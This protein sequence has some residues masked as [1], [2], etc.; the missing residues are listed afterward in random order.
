MPT[1]MPPIGDQVVLITGASSGIGLV[2]ARLAASRGARV[3]LVSRNEA[4]LAEIVRGIE[5][6]GG[7]ACFAVADVGDRAALTRAAE[8]GIARFGRIDTWVNNAGVAIYAT[9]AETPDDE[10]ERL[11]RT[12][13]FGVVNGAHIAL[14]LFG[15]RGGAL[16]T[17]A[18]IAADMS[19]PIM[20]A[21]AASKHAV[22]AFVESLRIELKA[23]GSPISVSL[24]KPSGIATPIGVHAANHLRGEAMIPP[25]PYDPHLVAQAILRCAERPRRE[26]TVGGAGRAQVL[27]AEH[28]PAL[29]E[30]LAPLVVPFLHDRA[31]PKSAGSNLFGPGKDGD[32]RSSREAGFKLS[33]YTQAALRPRLA[34][35]LILSSAA[36]VGALAIWR[37]RRVRSRILS[38]P[39]HRSGSPVGKRPSSRP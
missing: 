10:H 6:E 29:F 34:A 38:G 4:A 27:F 7:Q 13:Y 30:R 14:E 28:F 39:R 17:V 11:F 20:G 24:I 2:T 12:N 16:I 33:P 25:P 22:R 19:S 36:A 15:D 35:A 3:I 26:I 1:E 18:S 8:T 21:Y 23:A 37:K 32:E 5:A 9:L 31:I